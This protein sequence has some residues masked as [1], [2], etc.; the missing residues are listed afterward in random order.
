VNGWAARAVGSGQ[1]NTTAMLAN[2]ATSYVGDT[3]RAAFYSDAL[4]SG[5]PV[6]CVTSKDDWFLGSIGEMKLMYDNLQGLGGFVQ[7]YYWSSTEYD[8]ANAW[9]QYFDY[10]YQNFSSKGFPGYVRPIRAF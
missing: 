7:N 9:S 5:V 3:S 1:A 8:A 6:G 2:G 4:A 10:G